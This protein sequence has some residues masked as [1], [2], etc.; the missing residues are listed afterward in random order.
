MILCIS[1]KFSTNLFSNPTPEVNELLSVKWEPVNSVDPKSDK[2]FEIN[3]L[4]IDEEIIMKINPEPERIAFWRKLY[5]TW[6]GSILK[7]K[8]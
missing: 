4:Q 3:Y 8:F 5:K 1:I 7:P 2:P 6:N